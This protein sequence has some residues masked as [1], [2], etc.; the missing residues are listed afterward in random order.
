MRIRQADRCH[1]M[2]AFS[3]PI[4]SEKSKLLKGRPSKES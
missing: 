1:L 3:I 4:V 2:F